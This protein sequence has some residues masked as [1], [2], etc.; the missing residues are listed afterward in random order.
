VDDSRAGLR[1]KR[2]GRGA[3]AGAA[4]A[5]RGG[6][7]DRA[8][9]RGPLA[10][11]E[12]QLCWTG[13]SGEPEGAASPLGKMDGRHAPWRERAKRAS[14]GAAAGAAGAARGG[15]RD[16]A[17]RGGDP[18]GSAGGAGR[19]APWR[20]TDRYRNLAVRIATALLLLPVALWLTWKG[21]L[22]F[23]I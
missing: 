11:A 14:R 8:S 4:G 12:V 6:A 20:M 3:A 10:R 15:A 21:G 2:A 19:H 1:A 7:R 18:A 13:A 23:A 22:P 17:S 16:P 9:R 5:A